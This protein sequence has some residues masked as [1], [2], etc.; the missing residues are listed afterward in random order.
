MSSIFDLKTNV[1]QLVSANQGTS[2][3][4]YQQVPATR[5]V[6]TTNFSNG[7]IEFRWQTSGQKWWI[8]NRSYIRV[9]CSLTNA[10]GNPLTLGNDIAPNMGLCASLFQSAEFRI[11]DK[12]VSRIGDYLPQVDALETR[13]TKSRSWLNGVGN[14]V[15]FWQDDFK[16]RQ[17][18]VSVD[19]LGTAQAEV[20][21][22]RAGLAFS[23]VATIE[24]DPALGILTFAAGPAGSPP[25]PVLAN[26]FVIGDEIEI[27][28]G[29]VATGTVRYRISALPAGGLT[30]QLNNT[31]QIAPLG[32]AALAFSRI[33]KV[34]IP[35]GTSDARK[36]ST[37]ELIW[38][39]PLSM[40]KIGHAIPSGKFS[41]VLSPQTASVYQKAAIESLLGA[42]DKNPGADFKFSV[43]SMYL[44]VNTV[45]GD[46]C[47]DITYLLDLEQ[48][49]CQADKVDNTS[50]G[51]KS[52]DVSPST[53]ALTVAYQD[54]RAG[55][56]TQASAT[57]FKAYNIA[58]DA[59]QET[60]LNR[61][62]FSYAGM[63]LPSP[64]ADPNYVASVGGA[65][66]Q[67]YTTQRYIESQIYNGAFYDSG[68]AESIQ[69]YKA[70]G[71]YYYFSVPR[72]GTD[73]STR[74]NVHQQFN[75][76]DTTNMRVLLFDH[77]RQNASIRVQD[78]RVIDV[79]L[80]DA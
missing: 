76:A 21:L 72:D 8:P 65:A 54:T 26:T 9:R 56:D 63:Q 52:W 29:A 60:K 28:S 42:G 51:Q 15:N 77:S 59:E 31:F 23:P 64:D 58:L 25:L 75:A 1:K 6:T 13:L 38:T 71:S 45:E 12:T 43:D 69:E 20:S 74:V 24:L 47:D 5:D 53:Y 11:N 79:Q 35:T 62:Y 36:V 73:R 3:M 50:F 78:G 55:T 46:R 7:A 40:F 49:R 32:P 67:D 4:D 16:L 70:R 18:D 19:N 39:P 80:E 66:G 17:Q 37:F 14:A 41:L 57:K 10:A 33:R 34:N 27:V 44:Y 2:R 68:G 30:L 22:G 61:F 48:T